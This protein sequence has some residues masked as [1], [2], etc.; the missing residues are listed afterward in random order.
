M[1]CPHCLRMSFTRICGYCGGEHESLSSRIRRRYGR[2]KLWVRP[3]IAAGVFAL[4]FL[5]LGAGWLGLVVGAFFGLLMGTAFQ[6][7]VRVK[8][9][10]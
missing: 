7:L 8:R 4:L 10:R 3:A 5:P 1:V 2:K 6:S 9:Y